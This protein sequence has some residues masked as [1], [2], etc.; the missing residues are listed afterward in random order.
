MVNRKLNGVYLAFS[1]LLLAFSLACAGAGPVA[2]VPTPEP[3]PNIAQTVEVAVQA[4]TEAH[5]EPTAGPTAT[6]RPAPTVAPTENIAATIEAAVGAT[7]VTMAP[8]TPTPDTPTVATP[9]PTATVATETPPTQTPL[10]APTETLPPPTQVI[11]WQEIIEWTGDGIRSTNVFRVR[12]DQWR[13]TWVTQ[14]GRL[15]DERFQIQL[16]NLNGTLNTI[17]VDGVNLEPG[18]IN[19]SGAGDYYLVIIAAQPY[20]ITAEGM[21]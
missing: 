9:A 17:A 19:L 8:P 21:R 18:S 4:T 3:T 6:A 12:F 7:I 20:T 13:L 16:Y 2:A 11:E 14:P 15:G 10:P 1:I 5:P